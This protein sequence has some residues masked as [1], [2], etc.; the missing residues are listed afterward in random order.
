MNFII[1]FS[2]HDKIEL[3]K[4][5]LTLHKIEELSDGNNKYIFIN[6]MSLKFDAK[7]N[8]KFIFSN[9]LNF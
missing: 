6:D 8:K 7:D 1:C 9:E 2:E 5:G 3:E 4:K